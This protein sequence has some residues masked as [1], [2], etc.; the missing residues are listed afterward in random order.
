MY[1]N[2]HLLDIIRDTRNS[3]AFRSIDT[4]QS[5]AKTKTIHNEV[6]IYKTQRFLVSTV[7]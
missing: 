6:Q 4:K 5:S 7:Q 2:N 1:N 3:S